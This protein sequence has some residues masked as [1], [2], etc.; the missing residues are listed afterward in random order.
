MKIILAVDEN[1]GIGKGNEMLFHLSTD[2]KHFKEET[3]HNIVIMGRNTYESM[4]GGLTDRKNIVLSRNTD[5]RL[6]DAKVF[7]DY[8]EVLSFVENSPKEAYVIGGS[9]IVDIFLPFCNEAIIT[10]IYASRDADT[11]LHNFD[12]D[13]NFEI[14][15][16]SGIN[17]ENGIKF[18]YITYRRK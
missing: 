16:K 11:Y 15:N 9:Q 8:K 10:K 2:L 12:K 6:D 1:W 17:K 14:I 7:N 5:Y 4:G 3:I 13:N 18:E